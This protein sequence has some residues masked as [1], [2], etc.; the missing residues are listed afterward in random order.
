MLEH[1]LH[2]HV[3]LS[4]ALDFRSYTRA[5]NYVSDIHEL[6][7]TC[8]LSMGVG[9]YRVSCRMALREHY[10]RATKVLNMYVFVCK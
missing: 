8:P 4:N 10:A 2:V 3:A 5:L 7:E 6:K 1:R 9:K